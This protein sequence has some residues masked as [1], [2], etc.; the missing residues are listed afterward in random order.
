MTNMLLD[1]PNLLLGVVGTHA[2]T[3]VESLNHV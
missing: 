2:L 3:A 1:N